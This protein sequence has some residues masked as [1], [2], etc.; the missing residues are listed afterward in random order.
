MATIHGVQTPG[1]WAHPPIHHD[2][3][4]S[5]FGEWL[6]H[7]RQARGLTLDDLSRE[8]KISRR[9]LEAL[10]H[11]DLGVI[12]P[13]YER[14][15]VR[16]IAR[17]VGIDERVAMVRLDTAIAPAVAAPRER[18]EVPAQ[19]RS[20]PAGALPFV[21]LAFVVL[22]AAGFGRTVLNREVPGRSENAGVTPRS[23]A[24]AQ[25]G[26]DVTVTPREDVTAL[27]GGRGDA[28]E[29][30]VTRPE[31]VAP[32]VQSTGAAASPAPPQPIAATPSTASFT[33]IVVTTSPPGATVTVNGISWGTSP[34]TIRHLPP[35]AKRIR[36]TKE[37]FAAAEQV[38][39]LGER[40]QQTL[41]LQLSGAN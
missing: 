4:S 8:T 18:L 28:A 15:E 37:G 16:A 24:T 12:P 39:P 26:A 29:K 9:N 10:E 22:L 21:A 20:S 36:A 17:A 3:A 11:G 23:T 19:P 27:P 41:N 38:V 25:S 33:E 7:E 2:E 30:P 40:Q 35:G 13:F 31:P 34:V 6:M 14:A 5:G 32:A 1:G